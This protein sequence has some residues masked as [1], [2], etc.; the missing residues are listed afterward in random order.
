MLREISQKELMK[1]IGQRVLVV[2]IVGGVVNPLEDLVTGSRILIDEE[3][4][5]KV[6]KQKKSRKEP[7]DSKKDH[8]NKEQLILKAW[9]GGERTIKEIMEVTG[10]SYATVRK[11]IPTTVNG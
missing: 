5:E 6:E 2:N 1:R 8:Y 7:M 9:N 4:K 10:C 11:Y 3:E